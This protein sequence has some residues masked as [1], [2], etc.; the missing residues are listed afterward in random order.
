MVDGKGQFECGNISKGKSCCETSGLHSFEMNFGYRE[1][2]EKKNELVKVRLCKKCSRKINRGKSPDRHE[3]PRKRSGGG[4]KKGG[5]GAASSSSVAR[6][7]AAEESLPSAA[8]RAQPAAKPGEES[9]MWSGEA[10]KA[11]TEESEMDDY[12]AGLFA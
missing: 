8:E 10:H 7:D 2:D 6:H 9:R 4:E 3:E 12:L 11:K 1:N 5:S